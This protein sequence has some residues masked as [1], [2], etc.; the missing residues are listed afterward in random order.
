MEYLSVRGGR[1]L[2][3]K[4]AI[5]SAK[6]SVLPIIACC[7]MTA[8]EVVLESIPELSDV[9]A[10]M[11][12]IAATGGR[13]Y[14]QDGNAVIDCT[15]C[16]PEL[17]GS[18]LTGS[19]R[20]SIFI[21]GPILSRYKRAVVSYPGGC[22]IGLRPIDL[23]IEG[24]RALGV[25]VNEEN[26]YIVCDGSAMHSG[27]IDLD[28]PSVGATENIMMAAVLTDGITTVRN[29]AR[30]PEIVDLGKF[31]SSLGGKVYGCGTDTITVEGVKKLAPISYRPIADR[32]VGATYLTA[33]AVTGGEV[34]LEDFDVRSISA[35]AEKLTR[36]GCELCTD[37]GDLIIRSNGNLKAVHKIET[38]PFPGFPTDM[39][40][41]LVAML[42]IAQGSS[43]MVENLFENRYKYTVQLAKMGAKIT[44]RDRIAIIRGVK[45]LHGTDVLAED[46]RGGAALTIAALGAE[47]N[48]KIFA[49]EHI[50][51][52][53]FKL[54]DD[55][56]ALGANIRR[57]KEK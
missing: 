24:L 15:D 54:E 49:P 10:M 5:K 47:G 43:I 53:Y 30:E 16:N 42:A 51:R 1:K 3:G 28:F 35:V 56:A 32:I 11:R 29:C 38:Q 39:Q 21:L 23:H 17:I 12:I 4:V 2:S 45:S 18:K 25:R 9:T 20:S 8:G 55:L 13:A 31:I 48:S 14:Y 27:E 41:Q 33:C 57:E 40:A 6:N 37:G 36:A 7:L 52:G 46:L 50:D 44:V 22:D 34:A 19:I 26:G